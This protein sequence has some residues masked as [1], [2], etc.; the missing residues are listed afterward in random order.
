MQAMALAAVLMTAMGGNPDGVVLNFTASWCGPCQQM[1]PVVSRLQQ[2]GYAIR[3]VDFDRER[4]L[5]RQFKVTGVPTFVLLIG[6]EERGRIS[7]VL[8]ESELRRMAGSIPEK[9]AALPVAI[10][11]KSSASGTKF[12]SSKQL[13][14]P[15]PRTVLASTPKPTKNA[16]VVR[17]NI[18]EEANAMFSSDP[19][20]VSVRLRVTDA[21]GMDWGSGTVIFSEP[22]QSLILTCGHV[23][24]H[25][26]QRGK[27]EVDLFDG[28]QGNGSKYQRLEG[29]VIRYD[30]KKDIGLVA[31]KSPKVLPVARISPKAVREGDLVVSVGC[32]GGS[33]PSK[34]QHRVTKIAGYVGDFI[35]CS[36]VPMSGR[37][38]GGLFS[39]KGEVVGVC[40]FADP[41]GRSGL[42]S[43]M[44]TIR[45]L[46]QKSGLRQLDPSGDEDSLATRS[47]DSV[48]NSDRA[49][50]LPE[51][52]ETPAFADSSDSKREP[53]FSDSPTQPTKELQLDSAPR[54]MPT[55]AQR[56]KSGATSRTH[57]APIVA[58]PSA[59][60]LRET[61]EAAKGAEVVCIIRDPAKPDS[62]SRVV[63]IH[64]ASERFV[65]DLTGEVEHQVQR[66]SL[67]VRGVSNT[68]SAAFDEDAIRYRRKK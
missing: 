32:G 10:E 9:V 22:G 56:S 34:L 42:Y 55:V 29:E 53:L 4:D 13:E 57:D 17:A 18:G 11:S 35:E 61:L 1:A 12:W 49:P 60:S 25:F 66:T 30:L 37:S 20:K 15:D 3:K 46:L 54:S 45:E 67:P 26:D 51:A 38:G 16:P 19:M 59:E 47:I 14:A 5:A 36:G 2:Q 24:R 31:V 62:A 6:G 52:L 27:V 48:Q 58:G 68:K 63:I 7:G 43:G 65:S 64:R 44:K 8:S 28:D 50:D 41:N 21:N 33:N 23:F 40:V 39:T